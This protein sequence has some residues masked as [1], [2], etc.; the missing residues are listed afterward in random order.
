MG[1]SCIIFR[2]VLHEYEANVFSPNYMY[3]IGQCAL[4]CHMVP[5]MDGPNTV[6]GDSQGHDGNVKP[7]DL[8]RTAR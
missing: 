2:A 7:V 8:K 6:L 5:D 4:S 3:R 1:S